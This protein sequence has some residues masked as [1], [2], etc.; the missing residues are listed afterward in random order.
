MIKKIKAAQKLAKQIKDE[1]VFI[2]EHPDLMIL[3]EVP[4]SKDQIHKVALVG[5]KWIC[6]CEDFYYRSG[7]SK[8]IEMLKEGFEQLDL[9]K[10]E[11]EPIGSYLCKHILAVLLYLA[12]KEDS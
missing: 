3:A 2:S 11:K 6:Y 5:N 12:E 8:Y 4:G 9:E 7:Y 10:P 1:D